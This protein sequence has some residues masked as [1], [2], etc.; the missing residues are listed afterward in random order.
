LPNT[1]PFALEASETFDVGS[2]T[3]TGVDDSDYQAP[4]AFDGK[5]SS[6]KIELQPHP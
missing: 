2:D 5:L 6:L 1:I 4:F 3:G